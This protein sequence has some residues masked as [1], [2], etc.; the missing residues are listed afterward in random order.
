MSWPKFVQF[1]LLKLKSINNFYLLA[2]TK[3][4]PLF[5]RRSR[6]RICSCHYILF[7]FY[8]ILMQITCFD[9]SHVSFVWQMEKILQSFVWERSLVL[10]SIADSLTNFS[11]NLLTQLPRILS[12]IHELGLYNQLYPPFRRKN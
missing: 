6:S 4:T 1:I 7:I 12:M 2:R 9:L 11:N 3:Y 10:E 8:N 5:F